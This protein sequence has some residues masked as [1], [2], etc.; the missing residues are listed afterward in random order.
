MCNVVFYGNIKIKEHVVMLIKAL[1]NVEDSY[2]GRDMIFVQEDK[3]NVIK[4]AER[5]FA[6][7]LYHQFRC[8]MKNDCNYYLNGE[9]KKKYIKEI[10]KICY[11]D[12]VLHGNH[13]SIEKGTQY[14][15]CEI[16]MAS[17]SNLLEDLKKIAKLSE[18]ELYFQEYIFLCVGLSKEELEKKFV[19]C[20][21]EDC[22]VET[23]CICRK[24]SV[25]EIFRLGEFVKTN[26][27][28]QFKYG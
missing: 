22:N 9:I 11:P 3:D 14:F 23:L 13:D 20:K 25:I 27:K 19:N 21:I 24:N 1:S 18:S 5:V 26:N 7:E 15:L 17:N 6:Y 16:K 12:L 8:L 2:L 28:E 4:Y 10:E